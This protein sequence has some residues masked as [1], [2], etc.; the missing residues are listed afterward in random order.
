MVK[1]HY[2]N[3]GFEA[4]EDSETSQW[5]LNVENYQNRECYIAPK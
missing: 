4:I 1:E 2:P 5:I 3:L